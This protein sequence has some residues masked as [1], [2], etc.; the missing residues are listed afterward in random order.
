L[1]SRFISIAAFMSWLREFGYGMNFKEAFLIAYARL[2][3]AIGISL[4]MLVY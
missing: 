4:A 2:K 3:G 1:V